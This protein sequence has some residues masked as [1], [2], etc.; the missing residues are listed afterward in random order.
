MGDPYGQ[1]PGQAVDRKSVGGVTT[2]PAS[3]ITFADET[4]GKG[5]FGTVYLAKWRGLDVAVKKISGPGATFDREVAAG[6]L[7]HPNIVRLHAVCL[8]D[9][10]LVFEYVPGGDLRSLVQKRKLTLAQQLSIARQVAAA[11]RYLHDCDLLHCDVKCD[12]VLVAKAPTADSDD[13]IVKLGDFGLVSP[14]ADQAR[15]WNRMITP[16]EFWPD[17][18]WTKSGEVYA[19]ALLLHELM[20]GAQPFPG[21]PADGVLSLTARGVRPDVPSDWP[22]GLRELI[23]L[24]W[25]QDPSSR[26]AFG[27]I[28]MRLEG[29]VKSYTIEDLMKAIHRNSAAEVKVMLDSG[30]KSDQQASN[31]SLPLHTA[32]ALGFHEVVRVLLQCGAN[33]RLAPFGRTA[34]DYAREK[35]HM[36]VVQMLDEHERRLAY[37][38][39]QSAP[40]PMNAGYGYPPP[41]MMHPQQQQ[42]MPRYNSAPNLFPYNL[43]A[44]PPTLPPIPGYYGQQMQMAPPQ[45]LG[46][47]YP[48]TVPTAQPSYTSAPS[49]Y[50]VQYP[51]PP[52]PPP[53]SAQQQQ[54]QQQQQPV[55]P[56]Q[57]GPATPTGQVQNPSGA[58]RVQFEEEPLVEEFPCTPSDELPSTPSPRRQWIASQWKES[59]DRQFA[60]AA[61]A[62]ADPAAEAEYAPPALPLNT[63]VRRLSHDDQDAHVAPS[64]ASSELYRVFRSSPAAPV[65]AMART[66]RLWTPDELFTPERMQAAATKRR[67]MFDDELIDVP[68]P[69]TPVTFGEMPE[70]L[71]PMSPLTAA[72]PVAIQNAT[73][74]SHPLLGEEM[75]QKHQQQLQ[76]KAQQQQQQQQ[77]QSEEQPQMESTSTAGLSVKMLRALL[78]CKRLRTVV[79]PLSLAEQDAV[80]Y[81]GDIASLQHCGVHVTFKGDRVVRMEGET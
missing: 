20:T 40:P 72:P 62:P 42:Q 35:Q 24:C 61:A 4:L 58:K 6:K 70:V 31:G 22:T 75:F 14:T 63:H 10:M 54:Q 21:M 80:R 71:E 79:L 9:P 29:L 45:Q 2:V 65:Y 23:A 32:A 25:H 50:G 67:A 43:V 60:S 66:Q 59:L 64:G 7:Y 46:P 51:P 74:F 34:I 8:E 53:P 57:A 15:Q 48:F 73:D 36:H 26:P 1:F 27:L 3:E 41:Q 16:P 12:N 38:Q 30:V 55:V 47:Q 77:Q 76:E 81:G 44:Q 78:K 69:R 39:H 28:E 17:R 49:P 56:L 13:V 19:F 18:K 52:P 68:T 5:G 11:L 37:P 33:H